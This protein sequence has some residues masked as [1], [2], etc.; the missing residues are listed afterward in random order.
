MKRFKI[1]YEKGA[2]YVSIPNYGGGEVVDALS[3]DEMREALLT[4]TTMLEALL[5]QLESWGH[6]S[7]VNA[8]GRI[9]EN[10]ELLAKSSVSS[11]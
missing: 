4:S 2:Y 10:E 3:A 9:F 5:V 6:S 8:R 11:D 7:A 1:K